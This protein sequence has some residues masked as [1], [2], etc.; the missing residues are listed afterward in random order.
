[1]SWWEDAP[2]VENASAKGA[3]PS[4][5]GGDWWKDAPLVEGAPPPAR[6]AQAK[7]EVPKQDVDL[8]TRAGMA[9]NRGIA[10]MLGAPADF[11]N[12]IT[13]GT[14]QAVDEG[15]RWAGKKLGL[16]V[17]DVPTVRTIPRIPGGSED[18]KRGM[19]WLGQNTPL[20]GVENAH[21]DSPNP[22]T[23]LPEKMAEAAGEGVAMAVLP[24]MGAEALAAKA[25]REIGALGTQLAKII[26]GGGAGSNALMGAGS[27]IAGVAAEDAVPETIMGSKTAADLVRPLARMGGEIAGGIPGAVAGTAADA[28]LRGAKDLA[29]LPF[30]SAE[31]GAVRKALGNVPE[32]R[33][34]EFLRTLANEDVSRVAPDKPGNLTLFQATGDVAPKLGELER[35]VITKNPA[36]AM[37]VRQ[38]QNEE[39]LTRLNAMYAESPRKALD[40][41]RARIGQIEEEHASLVAAAR[42]EAEVRMGQ[43]GG[44]MFDDKSGYGG[45]LQ[46]RLDELN[47]AKKVAEGKI[48]DEFRAVAGDKPLPFA[49]AKPRVRAIAEDRGQFDSDIEGNE[50]SIFNK[51]LNAN[52]TATFKDIGRLQSRLKGIIRDPKE[53]GDTRNRMREV[54][55]VIDETM[56]QAIDRVV[57]DGERPLL[58][59]MGNQ[60]TAS[61]VAL[62]GQGRAATRERKETFEEG[63]VG[64]VLKTGERRGLLRMTESNVVGALLQRPEDLRAFIKAAGNDA[65]S[66]ELAQ[67]AL[68]FDMRRKATIDGVISPEKLQGWMQNNT[69]AMRQFPDLQAKFANARTASEALDTAIARQK[70]ALESSQL[71]AAQK[72]IG[73]KDPHD[74]LYEML[75]RPEQLRT[76]VDQVKQD[77]EAYAGLKRL[78]VELIM[79][80]GGVVAEDGVLTG[81]KEAG[82]SELPQL[83]ANAM[84][85][86]YYNNR[87]SLG[88]IFDKEGLSNID[89]VMG[90]IQKAARTE[91]G[92]RIPGQSNSAQD[93]WSITKDALT[94]AWRKAGSVIGMTGGVAT[95]DPFIGAPVAA[96]G[97]ALDA[98]RTAY[99]GRMDAALADIM[100]DVR[101]AQLAIPKVVADVEGKQAARDENTV[102]RRMR[103]LLGQEVAYQ[104]EEAGESLRR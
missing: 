10:T 88:E 51:I 62:Y 41:T 84:Q 45:A 103:A 32:D 69:E 37:E 34:P 70:E 29:A 82:T 38:G 36:A 96:G 81:A 60:L 72:F 76:L 55:K 39:W 20:I 93:L 3:P 6:Q 12:W 26:A 64:K 104:L 58:D 33:A 98:F 17:D 16:N 11:S 83:A 7:P 27:G 73:D 50:A 86:F 42:K 9:M 94:S 21:P 47:A 52:D 100:L 78:A 102:A 15:A 68:A 13:Q 66:M 99:R 18:I 63:T 28:A 56:D 25:S 90:N 23:T 80:R 67:D 30:R 2:L 59:A 87:R 46:E 31:E 49:E 71:K 65:R 77:P 97:I 74:T 101:K 1:M 61:D 79:R 44:V 14:Q 19:A 75:Q 4:G 85:K 8:A 43:T 24:G 5:S 22:A 92:V 48:W 35:S 91:G 95:M 40:A 54:L 89:S 57:I 53:T